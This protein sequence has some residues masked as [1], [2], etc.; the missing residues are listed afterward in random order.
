VKAW[1]WRRCSAISVRIS[2]I[3]MARRCPLRGGAPWLAIESCHTAALGGHVERCGDCGHQRICYSSCRNRN[4]P[5][6]QG[7][8]RAQWL[9]DR[10]AELI[11]V[12]YFQVVFTVPDLIASIEGV[13]V[14]F[15]N[16]LGE[17]SSL[18]QVAWAS[19][20]AVIFGGG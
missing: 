14:K 13:R 18:H 17:K 10:Q 5:K 8:A 6:C 12:P 3:D 19:A 4:C 2:A 16:T 7:L 1:K 11:D 9:E 15:I 20:A